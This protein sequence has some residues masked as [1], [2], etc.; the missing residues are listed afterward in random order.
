MRNAYEVL[1]QKEAELVRVRRELAS[2]TIAASLLDDGDLSFFD[3]SKAADGQSKK[4][5]EKATSPAPDSR[6]TG[7]DSASL[8]AR[9]PGFWGSLKR[10][11]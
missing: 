3:P 5:A 2:L 4:P 6:A 8:I 11:L 7:T 1:Y 9:R 10:K